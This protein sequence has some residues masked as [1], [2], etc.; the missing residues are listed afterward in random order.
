MNTTEINPGNAVNTGGLDI[1]NIFQYLGQTAEQDPH[2]M[3]ASRL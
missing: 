2:P 1:G 3:Q